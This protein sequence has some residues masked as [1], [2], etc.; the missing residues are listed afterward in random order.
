MIVNWNNFNVI[1]TNCTINKIC[2]VILLTCIKRSNLSSIVSIYG[3]HCIILPLC[4]WLEL[5]KVPAKSSWGEI[6]Y[7]EISHPIELMKFKQISNHKN[8]YCSNIEYEIR[9]MMKP[10]IVLMIKLNRFNDRQWLVCS[11]FIKKSSLPL[12]HHQPETI[13]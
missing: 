13:C 10:S 9:Q 5:S 8:M 4:T 7:Q 2:T 12:D 3:P 11:Q 6:R 1:Y